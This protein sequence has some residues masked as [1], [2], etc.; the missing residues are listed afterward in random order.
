MPRDVFRNPPDSGALHRLVNRLQYR[1]GG[2]R[3][4][5]TFHCHLVNQCDR[6]QPGTVLL[7]HRS[8]NDYIP[9]RAQNP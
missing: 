3:R 1:G 2:V 7:S 4:L 5:R 6:Q 8:G 9:R